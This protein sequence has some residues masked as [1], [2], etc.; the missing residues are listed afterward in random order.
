MSAPSPR[1]AVIYCR[2]SPRRD[3]TTSQSN[4]SQHSACVTFCDSKGYKVIG[5][6]QDKAAEGDDAERPGLWDAIAALPKGGVLVVSEMH[7]LA[8]CPIL[9]DAIVKAVRKARADIEPV[10][11]RPVSAQESPSEEMTRRIL[12]VVNAYQKKA[13]AA[14]TS[15]RMR[16][17]QANGI[18]VG[19]VPYGF[20]REGERLVE[21]A[22]EQAIIARIEKL[23]EWMT[24]GEIHER[25]NREHL[26]NRD[27]K[28]WTR[29]G[30]YRVLKR[31]RDSGAVATA[32]S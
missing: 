7:R 24:R 3:E 6:F 19:G 5:S 17:M 4:E 29:A 12:A 27:G 8:R 30:V 9:E 28:P 18:C 10:D 22:A 32:T 31:L 21:D 23:D 1:P 20:R 13:N 16:A 15:A 11:G 25:L 2:F 14:L 26:R